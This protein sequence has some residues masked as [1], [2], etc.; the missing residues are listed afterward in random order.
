M[1]TEEQLREIEAKY[2]DSEYLDTDTIGILL[3]E[4]RRLRQRVQELLPTVSE[5]YG[6]WEEKDE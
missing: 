3:A 5:L 1:L 6:A 2:R 4:V